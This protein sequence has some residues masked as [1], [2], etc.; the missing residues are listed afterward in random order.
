[1]TSASK[2]LELTAL[3]FV[4]YNLWR[5]LNAET[6]EEAAIALAAPPIARDTKVGDLLSAYPGLLPVFI[7]AGFTPLA[8]PLLRRTLARG[9]SVAQECRMHSEDMEDLL[10]RLREASQHLKA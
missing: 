2:V 8:N 9:I 7:G 5:I 10:G 6:L 4:G 3:L 1:V